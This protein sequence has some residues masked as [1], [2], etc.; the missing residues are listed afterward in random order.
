MTDFTPSTYQAA[1][2]EA[3]LSTHDNLR[4]AGVPGCGKTTTMVWLTSYIRSGGMALAFNKSI[5]KT[6]EARI[7]SSWQAKTFHSLGFEACRQLTHEVSKPGRYNKDILHTKQRLPTKFS[8]NYPDIAKAISY[9]KRLGVRVV[10]DNTPETW[11]DIIF[12]YDLP[13]PKDHKPHLCSL[14]PSLYDVITEDTSSVTFDDMLLFPLLHDLKC[15]TFVNIMVDELQDMSL[16]EHFF[17]QRKA[18]HPNGR[19]LGFGDPRQSI[20]GFRGADHRAMDHFADTF[21]T[22]DTPLSLSYRLPTAVADHVRSVCPELEVLPDAPEG[23]VIH[24]DDMPHPSAFSARSL[25]LCRNNAPL[26][27]LGLSF[28]RASVQCQLRMDLREILFSFIKQMKTDDINIFAKRLDEWFNSEM[29][30]AEKTKQFGR[31]DHISDKYETFRALLDHCDSIGAMKN[32]I[33]QVFN[34]TTGPIL[35]TVHKAKGLEAPDVYLLRP[36]LMPSKRATKEWERQQETNIWF[37]A[38]TRAMTNLHYLPREGE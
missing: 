2:R 32:T 31:M 34:K 17:I 18:M 3:V 22:R 6:L 13:I 7:P 29:A 33:T 9:G 19:I 28:L 36:D 16:L 10:I 12:S 15:R 4:S 21:N 14:L 35:S 30:D 11:D 37:V 8:D 1:V 26:M 23:A 25:I 24:H 20:Y 38:C 27:R 5:Q